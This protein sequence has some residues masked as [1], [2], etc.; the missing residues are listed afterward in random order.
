[1]CIVGFCTLMS[2]DSR[3]K[4]VDDFTVHIVPSL[5]KVFQ[6]LIEAY[7]GLFETIELFHIC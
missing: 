1:M 6:G 4:C 7:K 5:I 3:P 2:L